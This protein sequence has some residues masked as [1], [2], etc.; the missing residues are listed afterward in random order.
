M[1]KEKIKDIVNKVPGFEAAKK[2]VDE[3]VTDIKKEVTE[4]IDTTTEKA[5]TKVEEPIKH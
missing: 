5:E 2:N 3:N 4:K 1:K